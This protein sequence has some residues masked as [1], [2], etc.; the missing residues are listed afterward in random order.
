MLIFKL[1]QTKFQEPL[2]VWWGW[3]HV[4][5]QCIED[6]NRILLWNNFSLDQTYLLDNM[7]TSFYC[8]SRHFYSVKMMPIFGVHIYLCVHMY[9]VFHI[10]YMLTYNFYLSLPCFWKSYQIMH[11][12]FFPVYNSF[13][14]LFL[15]VHLQMIPLLVFRLY[16]ELLVKV[17]R[18]VTYF[19]SLQYTEAI[20]L[21]SFCLQVFTSKCNTA[22]CFV[23]KI[24]NIFHRKN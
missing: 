14:E 20:V 13:V 9:L 10:M 11:A 8:I 22:L 4:P 24:M 16:I 21:E 19:L 18:N 12:T 5:R 17:Y 23:V 6:T 7:D 1:F 2:Q 3:L 15:L